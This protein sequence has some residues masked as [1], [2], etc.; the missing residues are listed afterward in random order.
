MGANTKQD[1]VIKKTDGIIIVDAGAGTGKTYTITQRYLEILNKGVDPKD[2]FLVTF[3]KNAAIHMKEKVIL[4]ADPKIATD[5]IDAP[6]QNFDSFCFKI[7]SKYGLNA[8]KILGIKDNLSGYKLIS[9]SVIQKRIFNKF[10]NQFL[11]NNQEKYQKLLVSITNQLEIHSLIE[12]LLSKGIYPTKTGWF[13]DSKD[14]L[15]GDYK[16]FK[17]HFNKLNEQEVSTKGLKESDLLGKI[18]NRISSKSFLDMPDNIEIGKQINPKLVD[19]VFYDERLELIEFIHHVFIDYIEYMVKENSMTFS[20]IAMFAFLILYNEEEIRQINSFN[21]IM[22]D[23]FQDTN[24]MQFMLILLLLRKPNFCVV[25]DWKQGIYGFRNA[26]ISNIREFSDKIEKYKTQLNK[27]RKRILFDVS[28]IT[29]FDFDVNY[30]SSQKILTFSEKSLITKSSKNENIDAK[31]ICQNIVPLKSNFEYDNISDIKYYKAIDKET[32]INYILEKI[33]NLVGKKTIRYFDSLTEEYKERLIDFNDIAILSRTRN[34][35]LEIQQK[36]N[37]YNIPAVYEGG[38]KLFEEES[39]ILL[40]G[41]LKILL[42]K[43]KKDA[44]IPILEKEN[45]SYA[46]IKYI[47]ES[48]DYPK[49]I[50]EFRDHLLKNRKTINYIIDE[51]FKRYDFTDTISNALINVLDQVF[52]STLMSISDLIVFIEDNIEHGETYN[53]EI[54][55]A[56]NSVKI[57]TIHGS[58]GLEYPI[59]FIVNCNQSNFPSTNSDSNTLTFNQVSGIR[60]KRFYSVEHEFVF[61]NWKTE[62]ANMGLFCDM[63]EERRLLYVAITRAMYDVYFT[64]HRP[65]EFFNELAGEDVLIVENSNIEKLSLSKTDKSEEIKIKTVIGTYNKI[66]N[67]HDFMKSKQF[68]KGR[69]KEFGKV[70][71]KLAFRYIKGLKIS[72]IEDDYLKDFENIKDFIDSYT[73]DAKF[74]PEIDCSLFLQNVLVKGIIDLVVEFDDRI[75]I[76]D[77]KSDLV[78]DNIDEYSKQLSVYYYV[79]KSVYPDKEIICKIFWTCK[80]QVDVVEMVELKEIIIDNFE[81]LQNYQNSVNEKL[82]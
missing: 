32:E 63:D 69:G 71:H 55:R 46:Q 41:W 67:A 50:L 48:H 27:D 10:F 28:Q 61:D 60:N 30:R 58:K 76:I 24:E 77:W 12:T 5:I 23:E 45:Y 52:H 19:D 11:E 66:F 14:K 15:K 37:E 81:K 7:V 3:T 8:P 47:I 43:D 26:T 22:V 9:E 1:A 35:G 59:V 68:F 18:K 80:A 25:G 39:A 54:T 29:F 21:Y 4:K 82:L 56:S 2:I 70:L 73:K 62:I 44:W 42:Y 75:E 57:Q 17:E 65:S 38:I 49:E 72:R 36:A 64:A 33:Q 16:L 20:L 74:L 13:L 31:E 53:I 40:L 79:L 51:I 34:F 78:K 6:I